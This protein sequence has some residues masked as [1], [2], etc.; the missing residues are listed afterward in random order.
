VGK[1][2]AVPKETYFNAGYSAATAGVDGNAVACRIEWLDVFRSFFDM[3]GNR[4]D[5]S[6]HCTM[7]SQIERRCEVRVGPCARS[8]I[9]ISEDR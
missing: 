3:G 5:L 8:P 7:K 6:F 2:A 9:C 4:E 1:I